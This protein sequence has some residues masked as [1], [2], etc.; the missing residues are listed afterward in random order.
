M[1]MIV[2]ICDDNSIGREVL[3]ELLLE[4]KRQREISDLEILE[5]DSPVALARDLDRVESDVYLLDI[6]FPDGNGIDLAREIRLRYH[7]NPI[8]FITSSQKDTLNAFNVFALRYFVKPVRPKPFFET[9]DYAVGRL[10]ES[11]PKY[12]MINTT[13]GK[14]RLRFSTIMYVE[15]KNQVLHITM[16]TGK[17]YESVTLREA[18]ANKLRPLLEDDRFVQTHVS[19]VVNLDAVDA[20]RKDHMIMQDG[21]NIPISRTY[22]T[23]VKER[24]L[25]YFC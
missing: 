18:F 5:Y 11:A 17:V 20:Y 6:I 16:N 19:F 14:Q 21:R 12:F 25:S 24:Y 22:N 9:L 15:R 7:H 8:I 4:Y 2:S 1:A 10:Q 3:R 13:E 23:S